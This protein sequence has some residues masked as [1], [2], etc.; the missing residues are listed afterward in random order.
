V[1]D[2]LPAQ[3]QVPL[4][5]LRYRPRQSEEGFCPTESPF[6]PNHYLHPAQSILESPPWPLF[7]TARC[8]IGAAAPIL[9]PQVIPSPG[10]P[11]FSRA[12]TFSISPAVR[13][14]VFPK[15]LAFPLEFRH[16]LRDRPRCKQ[17]LEWISRHGAAMAAHQN[18]GAA[19]DGAAPS[20]APSA[21]RIRAIGVAKLFLCIP[22]R[23]LMTDRRATM[24]DRL[25]FFLRDGVMESRCG[26]DYEPRPGCQASPRRARDPK[27]R[28]SPARINGLTVQM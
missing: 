26:C 7:I 5:V 10:L 23:H 21:C 2:N 24:H 19:A 3:Q 13:K 20:P 8:D 12:L 6:P 14:M 17:P 22:D 9:P 15:R 28:L 18:A 16:S 4:Q 27:V 1:R 25:E 11:R